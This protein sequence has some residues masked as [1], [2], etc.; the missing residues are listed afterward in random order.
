MNLSGIKSKFTNY[1]LNKMK[2]LEMSVNNG[3]NVINASYLSSERFNP[4]ERISLTLRTLPTM[5]SIEKGIKYSFKSLKNNPDIPKTVASPDFID[6]FEKYAQSMGIKS[7]GY[8]KVPVDLI[9]KDLSIRY[10]NAIVFTKEM[11]KHAVDND[12]PR[13]SEKDL[14]LYNDFGKKINELADYLRENGFG[15][16][17]SHP[18]AGAVTYPTL[19]QNAGLGWRGNSNLLI[20]PEL[21][22]R[23]KIS[24]IFTSIEN[25]PVKENNE[26]SWIADYCKTCGKCLKVCPGDAIVKI[27]SHD[28]FKGTK[29]V[30]G[31]CVSGYKSCTICLKECPFNKR[32]YVSLKNRFEKITKKRRIS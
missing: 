8:T 28:G 29:L 7:I 5:L 13:K 27:E 25:L 19:A 23:Q 21:G 4:S 10:E 31:R 32:D 12:I 30:P 17:A 3:K 6:Q 9:F 1:Q 16:H 18:I 22:P 24:A 11:D 15:A 2:E 26:H 20:T 14:K